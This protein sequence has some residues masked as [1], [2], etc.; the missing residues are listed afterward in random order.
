MKRPGKRRSSSNDKLRAQLELRVADLVAHLAVVLER[1]L[2]DRARVRRARG[3]ERR[4]DRAANRG[5]SPRRVPA[6]ELVEL[7]RSPRMP[8]SCLGRGTARSRA[9][10]R[11]RAARGSRSSRAGNGPCR[12]VRRDG[13]R[14]R[15]SSAGSSGT[16]S[17]E[18]AREQRA[19][20]ARADAREARLAAM[21]Q[22]QRGRER[23][24]GIR[25]ADQHEAAA[26]PDVQRVRHRARTRRRGPRASAPCSRGRA[27][28]R[29][30]R[31]RRSRRARAALRSP[32][33]RRRTRCRLRAVAVA[34]RAFRCSGV[35]SP[36][37]PTHCSPK[38]YSTP[39]RCAASS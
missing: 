20:R 19:R 37:T 12:G 10:R 29:A 11:R 23:A 30:R 36:S 13:S 34:H 25:Q 14:S 2:G 33:R 18:L 28:L 17:G 6:D 24:V 35:P 8:R 39:W 1:H 31:W 22:E 21:R 26:R 38:R 27:A 4:E 3:L 9:P 16:A 5:R 15:C 32:R 7:R